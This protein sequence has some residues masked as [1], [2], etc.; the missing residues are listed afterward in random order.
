MNK[1]TRIKESL[2]AN[3]PRPKDIVKCIQ[4][5]INGMDEAYYDANVSDYRAHYSTN[6]C[7]WK[8]LGYVTTDK[9][10]K[11]SLTKLGKESNSFY[12]IPI[13]HKLKRLAHLESY[14]QKLRHENYKLRNKIFTAKQALEN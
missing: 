11:Y 12:A 9:N 2:G 1:I 4:V 6:F 5:T 13:S 14:N 7:T 3:N 8:R 10:H